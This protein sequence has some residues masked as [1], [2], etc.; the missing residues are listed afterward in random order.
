MPSIYQLKSR[1]QALLRP[2]VNAL[3][4]IGIT[5]NQI[6]ILACLLAVALGKVFIFFPD[7][8][9]LYF[10][11]PVFLFFRMALN[12]I[13]GMLAREHNM[14]SKLGA[15]LNEITD[16]IS[17]AALYYPILYNLGANIHFLIPFISL[18]IITEMTGVVGAQIGASRRYDGPFGKSDRAFL[19]S[20]ICLLH[21]FQFQ[22]THYINTIVVI[23]ILLS[24][25]TVFN[26][27]RNAL[28]EKHV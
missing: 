23:M 3:A 21:A 1:F 11:V 20:V 25:L 10:I 28:K 26:R 6:T 5:A 7:E 14:Q 12:A 19:I 22:V 17:D 9:G 24:G 4:K 8:L 27:V 18:A 13:D 2:I 15:F 16:V